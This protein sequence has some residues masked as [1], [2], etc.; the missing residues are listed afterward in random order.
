MAC[1]AMARRKYRVHKKAGSEQ[2][3]AIG[4]PMAQSEAWRSLSGAAV[5]VFVEL[6]TRFHGGNNG[7]LNLSLDEGARLLQLGKA[8]IVRALA[9]LTEK[10]FIKLKR[11]GRWYGRKASEYSLTTKSCEGLPG[12]NEWRQWRSAALP[13]RKRTL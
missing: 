1:L 10:G 3:L 6:H 8:T 12:T 2:Y 7:K 5:K 13:A 4:Y 9:E 11:R